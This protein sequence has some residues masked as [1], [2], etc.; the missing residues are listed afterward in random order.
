[1]YKLVEREAFIDSVRFKSAEFQGF[2][3]FLCFL[4]VGKTADCHVWVRVVREVDMVGKWFR[5]MF[6]PFFFLF[7]NVAKILMAFWV[8]GQVLHRERMHLKALLSDFRVLF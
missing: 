7:N 6:L 3:G 5:S 2:Y 8:K 4:G 1:M